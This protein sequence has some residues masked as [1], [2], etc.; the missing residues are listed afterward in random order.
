M[1]SVSRNLTHYKK[2]VALWTASTGSYFGSNITTL[3]LQV[4]VLVRLGGNAVDVGW[5]SSAR[6]L[7]YAAL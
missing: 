7:P 6:W 3:A 2:Y 4:L 1:E 5:V